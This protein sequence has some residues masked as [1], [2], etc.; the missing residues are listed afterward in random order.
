MTGLVAAYLN[1]YSR[2]RQ[3]LQRR[4]GCAAAAEDLSQDVY[5]RLADREDRDL[6][7]P[8][9]YVARTAANLALD[10]RR[11]AVR[12][13]VMAPFPSDLASDLPSAERT[14]VARERLKLVLQIA[15]RLP[16]RCREV[17]VLR[18]LEGL[19]QREI[20]ERLGISMNMVQKHLRKALE[21]IAAGLEALD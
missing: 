1:S 17:F 10:W 7:S 21:D 5:L 20:A 3:A 12:R 13:G 11:S 15:D 8:E 9:A 18:K 2:L 14:L 4:T 19:E 16:P 6:A